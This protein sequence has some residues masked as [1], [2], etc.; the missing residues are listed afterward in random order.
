VKLVKEHDNQAYHDDN[1]VI[2]YRLGGPCILIRLKTELATI[3]S[4]VAIV[5]WHDIGDSDGKFLTNLVMVVGKLLIKIFIVGYRTDIVALA[6]YDNAT[7]DYRRQP[8]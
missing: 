8:C 5:A 6:R 1:L 3:I 4:V 7:I 2:P